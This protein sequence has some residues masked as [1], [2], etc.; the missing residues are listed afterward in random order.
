MPGVNEKQMNVDLDKDVLTIRGEVTLEDSSGHE[1]TYSDHRPAD[2]QRSFRLSDEIDT[3]K[4]EASLKNGV[5]RLYLPKAAVAKPRKI[6]VK[7]G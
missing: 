2:F 5:L 3:E 4:I 1:L 6:L 7:A